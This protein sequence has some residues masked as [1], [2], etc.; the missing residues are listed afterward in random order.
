M[1]VRHHN[2]FLLL[3]AIYFYFCHHHHHQLIF[4]HSHGQNETKSK[5]KFPSNR[6]KREQ[7]AKNSMGLANLEACSLP[8]PL[9]YK[10]NW[11]QRFIFGASLVVTSALFLAAAAANLC[12]PKRASRS[13][14]RE[15]LRWANV[16]YDFFIGLFSAT[17]HRKFFPSFH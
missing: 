16:D 17:N 12:S 4:I 8:L 7:T 5:G 13:L 10:Q 6:S 9:N 2:N 3:L 11:K 14:E 15:E 1:P